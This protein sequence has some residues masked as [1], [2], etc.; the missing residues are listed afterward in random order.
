ML[1][2]L[3]KLI[4]FVSSNI[5]VTSSDIEK[6]ILQNVISIYNVAQ[7]PKIIQIKEHTILYVFF[8]S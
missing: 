8:W 1:L 3:I 6:M 2:N 4:L 7:I 5:T